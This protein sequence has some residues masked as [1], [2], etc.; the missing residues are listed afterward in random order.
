MKTS[1]VWITWE[2]HRRSKELANAFSASYTLF[3]SNRDRFFRYIILAFKTVV[4]LIKNKPR[5]VFCQNPSIVLASLL[6]ALKFIFGYQLVVDRHSNFKFHT[7]QSKHPIW[8]MFHALSNYSLRKADVTIITNQYLK[9]FVESKGGVACVLPD[10]LPEMIFAHEQHLED[11]FNIT[12]ISTFSDDEPI[13]EVVEAANILGE[14]FNVF[15]T[16]GYRKY[17]KIEELNAIKPTNAILTGF[18]P[19]EK[20]QEQL[21]SSDLIIV[22]TTFEYTLTCGAYEAVAL[23]KPMLLGETKTIKDYF[24]KGALYTSLSPKDLAESIRNALKER[25][26]LKLEVKQLKVELIDDWNKKFALVCEKIES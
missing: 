12:F 22:I 15:I 26:K 17:K 21:A 9:E 19:E 20:Y 16:G 25:D 11:G 23:E 6:C 14:G 3:E 10:K 8:K 1:K 5:V 7:L 4:F 24:N 13:F 18:L 2:D